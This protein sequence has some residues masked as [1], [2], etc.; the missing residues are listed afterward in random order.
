[1]DVNR[2]TFDKWYMDCVES[3]GRTAIAYRATM[4]WGPLAFSWQ[5]V[6][7]Y[8]LLMPPQVRT[9]LAIVDAPV[10]QDRMIRWNA[11]DLGCAIEAETRQDPAAI[12]LLENADGVIDWR[13]EAPAATMCMR[14]QGHE[15]IRGC[16][17]AERLILTMLPWRLPIDELRWGRWI[18]AD[19][20]HS[21]VWIDWRGE[22]PN[23]W[24]FV[25]GV[26]QHGATAVVRDDAVSAGDCVLALSTPRL[27]ETRSL[28]EIVK[29]AG[30]LKNL[31]PA[32]LLALRET[33]WCS[34]GTWRSHGAEPLS[35]WAI[36][37]KVSFR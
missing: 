2:F 5:S 26:R 25:D 15:P 31:L 33:K 20:S 18:A 8:D 37:E 30:A 4:A 12:R 29:P 14:V 28:D 21:M 13:C 22:L 24:V 32:S 23:T 11:P 7:V 16:G 9:S 10:H 34:S 36:H 3:D 27:L 6:A 1:M 17:Y 19:A 35:G